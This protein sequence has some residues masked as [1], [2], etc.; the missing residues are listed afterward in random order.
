MLA[1]E[2]SFELSE[3][4]R[5]RTVWRLDGGAGSDDHLRWL[6]AR[7]YHV[8]AKGISN[9]RAEALARQVRRWD[10]CGDYWI[11]EV[12]PPV[13]YGRPVRVFV[14]KRLKQGRFVHSYYV[15]TLSLS[16]KKLY[17]RYYEHRGAAE[18]EQFRNDKQG[19]G[20]S[21]SPKT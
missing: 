21:C 6:L 18:I 5:R 14:K 2:S 20:L 12:A 1:V 11:G 8:I 3:A 9:R 19:F 16:S 10:A 4:Q 7:G 13:E 17:L 15:S